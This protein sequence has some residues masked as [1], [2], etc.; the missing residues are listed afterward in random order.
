MAVPSVDNIQHI[1]DLKGGLQT[2]LLLCR[3]EVLK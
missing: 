2:Y 3:K 1:V